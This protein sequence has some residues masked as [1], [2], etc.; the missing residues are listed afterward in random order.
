MI[1]KN[2][3][4]PELFDLYYEIKNNTLFKDY[5]LGGGTA[6]ALQLGHRISTDIDIFTTSNHNNKDILNELDE[7]YK[8]YYIINISNSVLEIVLKNIKLDFIK[9]NSNIIEIPKT[10]ENITYF[11]VK[12]ISAM[13]LRA[14]LTRTKSRDYIDIAYIMQN[15]SLN[16]MFENYKCKYESDDISVIKI[17]LLKSK[18]I[19]KEEW[20]KDIYML[21]NDI[22]FES[23]P[24]LIETE[25]MKYNKKHNMGNKKTLIDKIKYFFKYTHGE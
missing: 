7:K 9:D 16:D 17:A 19:T 21:K 10:E 14:I 23:I 24:K 18:N 12:D 2:V 5:I 11:S 1:Y 25:L 3:A 22:K 20:E 6:L 4:K 13:K 15:M 8:N